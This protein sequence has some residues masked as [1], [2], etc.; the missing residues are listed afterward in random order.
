MSIFLIP[1]ALIILAWLS[2]CIV[3][4]P[5][6]HV[7]VIETFGKY[8]GTRNAG[9]SLKLPAPIQIASRP[10]SLQTQ[11]M[12]DNVQVK[13]S[14]N[15]FV[16][17]P[18]Y[19]QFRVVPTQI[20]QAFYE[21]AD[22]V[23]QM[24]SYVVA[25]I[26]ATA[27]KMSFQELYDDKE[28]LSSQIQENI[29]EKM[30]DYGYKIVDV[31]VDDPQPT[32]DIVRAFNDVTASVRAKE[33]AIGYAEAE[34]VRR[35]AEAEATGQAQKISANATAEARRILAEGNAEA[36]IKSVENTGLS[37]QY[38]H[39]LVEMSIAAETARDAS[40]QG[41]RTVLVMGQNGAVNTLHGLYADTGPADVPKNHRGHPQSCTLDKDGDGIVDLV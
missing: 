38:G 39:H 16:K 2:T 41:S 22:P 12:H 29:G 8:A 3:I 27:S 1:L 20:R 36:I 18:V 5:Q 37:A 14:D 23:S 40:R 21:L 24:R 15:V 7:K 25:E 13:S 10:F 34:R 26:R 35:V 28:Q 32:D 31:L 9:L 33:A 19:V 6:Q 30:H 17:I 11:Q 4:T